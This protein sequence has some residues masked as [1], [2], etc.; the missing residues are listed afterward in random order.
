MHRA[1]ARL[2]EER[3]CRCD[4]DVIEITGTRARYAEFL[5]REIRGASVRNRQTLVL[6]LGHRASAASRRV[7]R[8]LKGRSK[9]MEG[10][11]SRFSVAA[12][13]LA[14]VACVFAVGPVPTAAEE[15][16]AFDVINAEPAGAP[17]VYHVMPVFERLQ[18]VS[19]RR[20]GA[21]GRP[22]DR[23]VFTPETEWSFQAGTG[24]LHLHV[25]ID[26]EQWMV[27]VSGPRVMP[28]VWRAREALEPGSVRLFFE[29]RAGVR[30][31]DFTVDEEAGV[32]H[33]LR[34]ELC[35]PKRRYRIEYTYRRD[36]ERPGRSRGGAIGSL[37]VTAEADAPPRP[38]P[39]DIRHA[40]GTSASPTEDPS[41]YTL[42]RPMRAGDM[43]VSRARRGVTGS[44]TPLVRDRDYRY[45]EQTGTIVL[46]RGL[47]LDPESEY[48]F[49]YGTPLV[50]NVFH[51][52]QAIPADSVRVTVD[53][54]A[55][56]EGPGFTVD[57]E[58]GVLTIR[59][60]AAMAPH[61]TITISAGEVSFVQST[62]STSR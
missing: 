23:R 14:V 2:R 37:P 31:Q 44:L 36:P 54:K 61:V 6:A 46:L 19:A 7:R 1:Q 56:E 52:R 9:I 53:G 27:S 17:G 38:T 21:A 42:V 35:D 41:V 4:R 58:N 50:R 5:L 26:D 59:D 16:V 3:E 10:R 30:G 45:D 24:R 39:R 29:G 60:P 12:T 55:L 18:E 22:E 11:L 40:L 49:V 32:I 47:T 13:V 48:L 51:F 8:I 28:W 20:R 43:A 57:Y 15:E 25:P 34:R 33:F 62:S